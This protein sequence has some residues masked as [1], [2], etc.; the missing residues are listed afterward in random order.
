MSSGIG[1]PNSD[2]ELLLKDDLSSKHGKAK[3][4]K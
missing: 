4:A 3:V 1:Q 2:C